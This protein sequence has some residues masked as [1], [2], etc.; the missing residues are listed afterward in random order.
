MYNYRLLW[1][2]KHPNVRKELKYELS[3]HGPFLW[4]RFEE[5][6]VSEF[7]E[8]TLIFPRQIPYRTNE[9]LLKFDSEKKLSKN[10]I[11]KVFRKL[12]AS[13][14]GTTV[15]RLEQMYP[16]LNTECFDVIEKESMLIERYT[17]VV[18]LGAGYMRVVQ[19]VYPDITGEK[20]LYVVKH[21][22]EKFPECRVNKL[23]SDNYKI[24]VRQ[25]ESFDT[26]EIKIRISECPFLS[27]QGVI[28]YIKHNP[29]RYPKTKI[30]I[31]YRRK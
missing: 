13:F 11:I 16:T 31:D 1:K 20:I 9:T 25:D 2:Y 5:R 23:S 22:K 6:Y 29:T 27:K 19:N 17:M 18:H 7:G 21:L 8:G 30:D 26:D 4:K 24:Y 28:S 10:K 14:L 12:I 15:Q 3:Q